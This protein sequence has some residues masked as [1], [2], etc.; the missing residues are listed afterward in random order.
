[1]HSEIEACALAGTQDAMET[2]AQSENRELAEE[3]LRFFVEGGEKECFAALLFTC[4]DLIRPDVA[5]EVHPQLLRRPPCAM[6]LSISSTTPALHIE[7]TICE[8]P[9]SDLE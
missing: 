6:T 5:L 3:L 7:Q 8:P 9:G 2:T 4:Y 1:M